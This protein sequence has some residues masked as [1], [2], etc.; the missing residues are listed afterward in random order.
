M[1]APWCCG[2]NTSR[3]KHVYATLYLQPPLGAMPLVLGP[4]HAH[5]KPVGISTLC[6]VCQH[7]TNGRVGVSR[8]DCPNHVHC[9]RSAAF[10]LVLNGLVKLWA[11]HA[12]RTPHS[13]ALHRLAA[14]ARERARA[15]ASGRERRMQSKAPCVGVLGCVGVVSAT[16]SPYRLGKKRYYYVEA[17]RRF[18][19]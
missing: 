15:R 11:A 3:I 5:R 17:L 12:T 9:I 4:K 10:T 1:A 6:F 14:R 19:C 8:S 2:P 7:A 13:H 18:E 16:C